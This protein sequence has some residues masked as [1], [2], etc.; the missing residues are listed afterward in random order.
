MN[1]EEA[2]RRM[3]HMLEDVHKFGAG[4]SLAFRQ[5]HTFLAANGRELT[6]VLYRLDEKNE[7]AFRTV[8]TWGK[9]SELTDLARYGGNNKEDDSVE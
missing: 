7:D 6:N 1:E 4:A 2:M 8:M 5:L 9:I 3:K